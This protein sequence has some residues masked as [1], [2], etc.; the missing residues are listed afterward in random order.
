MVFLFLCKTKIPS[1]R[2][3]LLLLISWITF[4][5]FKSLKGGSQKIRSNFNLKI[6]RFLIK[7]KTSSKKIST[8]FF[9][10]FVLET[11]LLARLMNINPFDQ[12][13]VEQVKIETNKILSR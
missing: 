3:T 11:I 12:P 13:A 7:S 5:I 4:S 2:S 6:F 1:F 10:F 9:T 8:F